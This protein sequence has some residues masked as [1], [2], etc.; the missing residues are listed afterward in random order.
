MARPG[1]HGF[2][3]SVALVLS[4]RRGRCRDH[5]ASTRKRCGRNSAFPALSPKPSAPWTD[6][7][8]HRARAARAPGRIEDAAPHLHRCYDETLSE[9][10]RKNRHCGPM[11]MRARGAIDPAASLDMLKL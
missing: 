11:I 10:L 1:A 4:R 9:T 2:W 7:R 3:H 6:P 5:A 8:L